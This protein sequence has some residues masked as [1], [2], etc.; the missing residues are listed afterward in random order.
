M[1]DVCENLARCGLCS[2]GLQVDLCKGS[3][4]ETV[5]DE[6]KTFLIRTK[7]YTDPVFF[8]LKEDLP[9]FNKGC[10]Q[11]VL[12]GSGIVRSACLQRFVHVEKTLA[13]RRESKTA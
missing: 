11:G 4:E 7:G 12:I 6:D 13:I 2:E 8:I 9:V 1:V 5:H 3:L 10:S